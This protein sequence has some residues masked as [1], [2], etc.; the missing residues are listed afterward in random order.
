MCPTSRKDQAAGWQ[1]PQGGIDENEDP[2]V[3]AM[4]E[5]AEETGIRSADIIAQSADWHYYDLPPELVG[6]AWGGRY[7]GQKQ[8]W[9]LVRFSGPDSE[10]DISP[11]GHQIEFDTWRWAPLDEVRQCVVPFKRAV[12][13]KV[14]DEFALSG[15]SD[16]PERHLIRGRKCCHISSAATP[17]ASAL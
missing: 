2:A 5:L 3:A 9:F 7:K 1:M 10:V 17:P 15:D 6:K 13:D 4:R 16:R 12:Y 11:A 8:K 14:L